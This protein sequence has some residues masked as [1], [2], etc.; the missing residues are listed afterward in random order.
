MSAGVTR[1]VPTRCSSE[2]STL[3]STSESELVL[4]WRRSSRSMHFAELARI[5]EVAVVREADAVRRIHVERLGFGGAVAA[6]GRIAHVAH[7]D[8]ALELLHVVLLEHVAHQALALAHEQLAVGD[9]GDARGVLPAM[10]EHRQG[11]IDPLIDSAGSDDS[12]NAAHSVAILRWKRE[13]D[14]ASSRGARVSRRRC[15]AAHRRRRWRKASGGNS[16]SAGLRP[17]AAPGWR[18]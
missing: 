12:G 14:S 10:L 17:C 8:V 13:V 16:S 4:R 5:G 11:V 3:S 6:G 15:R 9:R 2:A 18:S 1:G 7:A